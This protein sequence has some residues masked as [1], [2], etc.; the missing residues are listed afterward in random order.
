MPS[1]GLGYRDISTNP[2]SQWAMRQ[3]PT[4]MQITIDG[5]LVAPIVNFDP[6]TSRSQATQIWANGSEVLYIRAG[7]QER[8][9][10]TRAT[11]WSIV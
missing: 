11:G 3:G 2:V 8:W 1:E 5:G 7:V 6:N 4:G 10:F 9:S